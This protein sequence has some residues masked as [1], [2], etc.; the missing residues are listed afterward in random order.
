MKESKKKSVT[1]SLEMKILAAQKNMAHI[2]NIDIS[3][4]CARI[5]G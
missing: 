1:F 4:I 3:L 2:N 5:K